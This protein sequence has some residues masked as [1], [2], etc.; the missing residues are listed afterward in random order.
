MC[1]GR[2]L[3]CNPEP[4]PLV[5][6]MF[7]C[8]HLFPFIPPNTLT[9]YQFQNYHHEKQHY[10]HFPMPERIVT[11]VVLLAIRALITCIDI[12]PRTATSLV[13]SGAVAPMCGRLLKIQDMDVAEACLKCLHLLS[14]VGR[15]V[16]SAGLLPR[17]VFVFL[18]NSLQQQTVTIGMKYGTSLH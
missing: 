10:G 5:T 18:E 15:S 4:A 13:E 9:L 17:S 6:V 2:L 1:Y 11:Q 16:G 8:S 3:I 12:T 14:K 7:R